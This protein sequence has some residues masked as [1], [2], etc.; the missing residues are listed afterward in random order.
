MRRFARLVVCGFAGA[1]GAGGGGEKQASSECKLISA[2]VSAV[3][4]C[5]AWP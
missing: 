1:G 4:L 5:S 3:L 2:Q